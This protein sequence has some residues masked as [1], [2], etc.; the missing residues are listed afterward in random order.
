MS[1]V[2]GT[3]SETLSELDAAFTR[4]AIENARKVEEAG[5]PRRSRWLAMI[6]RHNGAKRAWEAQPEAYSAG[7]TDLC[8]AGLEKLT[9]EFLILQPRF[10]RLFTSSQRCE[11]YALLRAYCGERFSA[12]ID[13][14]GCLVP[15]DDV[16]QG[17]P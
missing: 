9:V 12:K 7:F 11:A 14:Q 3:P 13:E 5:L 4:A 1:D 16:S 2:P 8:M 17:S 6:A 15:S 10:S